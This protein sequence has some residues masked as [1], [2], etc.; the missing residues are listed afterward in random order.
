MQDTTEAFLAH[1]HRFEPRRGDDSIVGWWR[2][3]MRRQRIRRASRRPALSGWAPAAATQQY[4]VAE[5]RID[6]AHKVRRVR[7][8]LASRAAPLHKGSRHK[9]G[10]V[11]DRVE[12]VVLGSGLA[13]DSLTELAAEV[14]WSPNQIWRATT[15]LR[16]HLGAAQS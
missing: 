11:L 2:V 4:P 15:T 16:A 9:L 6:L 5:R 14:G 7:L 1:A 12:S 8:A 13:S 3:T 10:V